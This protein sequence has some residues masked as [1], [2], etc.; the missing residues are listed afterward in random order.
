[1]AFPGPTPSGGPPADWQGGLYQRVMNA[2]YALP[3]LFRT[4]LNIAGVRATDLYTLNTALG[5]SIEESV[6]DNLNT[7]RAIW[8]PDQAFQLYSFVRQPQ[9]FPDVRLQTAASSVNPQIL[10]GI[11]LKGWFALAKEGEPSFRYT[12]TPNSC[13]TVDLLVVFPW[14]L[15]EIV[16]GHPKLLQPFVVEAR[17]AAE[18]RN[19]YWSVLRG[20]TG[21]AADVIPAGHQAPYPKKG[22][23]FNDSARSDSGG[24]FG[25]VARGGIMQDFI[26][27]LMQQPTAGIPLGAWQRFFRIFSDSFTETTLTNQLR[28]IATNFADAI[29]GTPEAKAAFDQFAESMIRLITTIDHHE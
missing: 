6:V 14:I 12:V 25:R 1:M 8:D 21:N 3:G 2:L 20:V 19:H 10:M 22:D 29:N 13:A 18:H 24:N 7:L 26:A 16:S 27:G 28:Q 15:D 5:A 23:K 11:E 17:F 4:S 9:V